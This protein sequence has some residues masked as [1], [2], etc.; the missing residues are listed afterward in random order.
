MEQKSGLKEANDQQKVQNIPV[1]IETKSNYDEEDSAQVNDHNQ[2]IHDQSDVTLDVE[3]HMPIYDP[4]LNQGRP[5][6]PAL[7]MDPELVPKQGEGLND[8]IYECLV[9][10]NQW[11]SQQDSFVGAEMRIKLRYIKFESDQSTQTIQ[12]TW[13]GPSEL[14]EMFEDQR[15]IV[16]ERLAKLLDSVLDFK[17]SPQNLQLNLVK[18][19]EQDS[20][21]ALES[22]T[23]YGK[24]KRA[25]LAIKQIDHA[26]EAAFV[27]EHL[28]TFGGQVV[29]VVPQVLNQELN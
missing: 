14:I 13:G 7:P 21:Y 10:F 23:E 8:Q 26:V 20:H 15:P 27:Q 16:L 4:S 1:I 19:D 29:Y 11:L 5:K 18:L 2:F 28:N 9:Q 12:F 22:L 3:E 17:A 24:R 25:R 6:H